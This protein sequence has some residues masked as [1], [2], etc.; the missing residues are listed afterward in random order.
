[1][2]RDRDA[3]SG[4][5]N[6]ESLDAESL[7]A[8]SLDAESLDA[9]SLDAES[10]GAES[11]GAESLDAESLDGNGERT[12]LRRDGS[13]PGSDVVAETPDDLVGVTLSGTYKV[14][15]VLGQGGMGRVYRA[16]HTRVSSKLYAVKVLHREF[17]SDPNVLARF[18]REAEAA[19]AITHPNVVGV[20]DVDRTPQGAPY[21][22]CEYLVGKDLSEQL[23]ARGK[24]DVQ[25]VLHI[26]LQVCAGVEAAHAQGVI[27]RD[28]KP[29]NVFLLADVKGEVPP[30]PLVKIL[31]FGLSRFLDGGSSELTRA[32]VIM[33]TPAYMAP[34]QA[35]GE[36][37]DHRLDVY[38][39]GTLLYTALSA[40]LPFNEE[41]PQATILA[42]MRASP[43]PIRALEPGVPESLAVI[44]E[45]A[46]AK[47]PEDRFGSVSELREAL[48]QVSESPSLAG[49]C[50]AGVSNQEQAG[51]SPQHDRGPVERGRGPQSVDS[52]AQ[53]ALAGV[54]IV[55]ALLVAGYAALI[56]HRLS[57]SFPLLRGE[58]HLR[59][60]FLA[61]T[62]G[63]GVLGAVFWWW[64]SASRGRASVSALRE[65]LARMI[66]VGLVTFALGVLAVRLHGS[67]GQ[68][69]PVSTK[70][71]GTGARGWL[72]WDF[73][74][75]V[76]AMGA[77][78][79]EGLGLALAGSKLYTRRLVGV[80]LRGFS[81]I[82]VIMLLG[83][84]FERTRLEALAGGRHDD[85]KGA[86]EPLEDPAD[87]LLLQ[88][89][90][91]DAEPAVEAL[92]P[93]PL[94]APVTGR[95]AS[96]DELRR[97]SDAGEAALVA[98]AAR[99]PEDPSVLRALAF[100]YASRAAG[101]PETMSV[102][103]KLFSLDPSMVAEPEL[104]FFVARAAETPGQ[105]ADQAFDVLE[106]HMGTAGPDLLYELLLRSKAA[107]R[108]LT[109][110]RKPGLRD[111]FTPE[112]AIAFDLR[113]AEGCAARLPLLKRASLEGDERSMFV[114]A[115]LSSGTR[116]GCG[117]WK[118]QPCKPACPDEA[119][120]FREVIKGIS[121]RV[122]G[123]RR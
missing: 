98:L 69:S 122:K 110:L 53:I 37:A 114:L 94:P 35:R 104:R 68:A 96:P 64:R 103:K 113:T 120:A 106:Y 17:A 80:L 48:V 57:L 72:G 16:Q 2:N 43:T 10:L 38:G 101:L 5:S 40:S 26:A 34:E 55:A 76:A 83:W 41:S 27:H 79:G 78:L 21:L 92:E 62:S 75:S 95:R 102:L 46:M 8:E 93:E 91:G 111:K 60:V 58:G 118:R 105:T 56:G 71:V 67:L 44:I 1:M 121:A 12:L 29:Q 13:W 90:E 15:H 100:K 4:V 119:P 70:G 24:L 3:K 52:S 63:L 20:Y 66:L 65:R 28:L 33:G 45:R 54:T 85:S 51:E 112:L 18:Q 87:E 115:S 123:A 117:R 61:G 30:R 89:V 19:A 77:S 23:R 7:D 39:I 22:V 109:V 14:E 32:G 81:I 25:T 84:G 97:A 42:V 59:V 6:A 50:P 11:L 116:R 82:A 88:P 49:R 73:V 86:V 9:E 108:A 36:R 107:E 31:D 74:L 99:F 47:R